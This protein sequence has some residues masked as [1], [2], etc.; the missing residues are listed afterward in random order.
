MPTYRYGCSKCD[1]EISKV[2]SISEFLSS[3]KSET[4]CANCKDGQLVQRLSKIHSK[5][6][7]TKEEQVAQIEEDVRKVVSK[8]HSGDEETIR[9]VYGEKPTQSNMTDSDL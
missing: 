1:F 9:K 4:L 6:E 8:V 3:R 2:M 7:R 5:I